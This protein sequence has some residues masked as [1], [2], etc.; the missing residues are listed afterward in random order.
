VQPPPINVVGLFRLKI[1]SAQELAVKKMQ[2]LVD[3]V[4]VASSLLWAG[5]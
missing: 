4:H 1:T 3:P 5:T 2:A